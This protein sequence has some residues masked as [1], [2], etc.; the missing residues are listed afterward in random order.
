MR[1]PSLA[2]RLG[3]LRMRP[4]WRCL[5]QLHFLGHQRWAEP[6]GKALAE[7]GPNQTFTRTAKT[8]N[9]CLMEAP[10]SVWKRSNPKAYKLDTKIILRGNPEEGK[11]ISGG[12]IG[13]ILEVKCGKK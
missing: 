13:D 1:R 12:T 11:T 3:K 6:R 7:G 2:A 9:E 5:E 10:C 4:P 8:F